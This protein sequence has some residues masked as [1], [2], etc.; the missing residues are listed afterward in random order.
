MSVVE[1]RS[2]RKEPRHFNAKKGWSDEQL[3]ILKT[4]WGVLSR[5]K[6]SELIGKGEDCCY[7]KAKRIGLPITAQVEWTPEFTETVK[8]L[9]D[10]GLSAREIGLRFGLTRNAICGKM[11]RIG[12][13]RPRPVQSE[14]QRIEARRAA[15][16]RHRAKMAALRPPKQFT[17]PTFLPEDAAR[18]TILSIPESEWVPFLET[19]HGH[20]RAI[21]ADDK[22]C[23]SRKVHYRSY[24]EGHAA[25]Y[26]HK[27][28]R[29]NA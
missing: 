6:I 21:M 25:I 14:N 13:S 8:K 5:K 16:K 23:C 3:E 29:Q 12:H 1:Y 26:Y 17:R 24:C 20:C 2:G 7:E 19:K 11:H 28:A 22:R 10:S 18:Q 9:R 15:L 4:N 27:T